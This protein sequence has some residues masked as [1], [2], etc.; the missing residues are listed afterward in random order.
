MA[1][2][3][4]EGGDSR[5][6]YSAGGK[7]SGQHRNEP[8]YFTDPFG[9]TVDAGSRGKT[10]KRSP[11]HRRAGRVLGTGGVPGGYLAGESM[12][13]ADATESLPDVSWRAA[14]SATSWFVFVFLRPME[15]SAP[16]AAALQK[17]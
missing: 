15:R 4:R 3:G 5:F 14:R 17:V 1:G 9:L 11:E 13:T 8:E 10:R 2:P 16:G 7:C 6:F 12:V